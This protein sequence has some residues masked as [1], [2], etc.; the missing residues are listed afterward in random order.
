MELVGWVNAMQSDPQNP[1]SNFVWMSSGSRVS[2][3]LWCPG[4][5]SNQGNGHHVH[6]AVKGTQG[7]LKVPCLNDIHENLDMLCICKRRCG[8]I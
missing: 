4:E 8:Y 1:S 2:E 3:T 6:L 7:G 5:P